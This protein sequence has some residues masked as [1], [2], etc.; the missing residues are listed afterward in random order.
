MA[1]L[2]TAHTPPWETAGP[3]NTQ[4]TAPEG[5]S[6]P[7]F[8]PPTQTSVCMHL[9]TH[10][11]TAASPR[12][13]Q[14]VV[15]WCN[16]LPPT[17]SVEAHQKVCTTGRGLDTT[18][19]GPPC[20]TA[21]GPPWHMQSSCWRTASVLFSCSQNRLLQALQTALLAV[22]TSPTSLPHNLR[23]AAEGGWLSPAC[24]PLLRLPAAPPLPAAPRLPH[25]LRRAAQA[26]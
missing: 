21:G 16:C 6:C 24:W 10:I 15:S 18:S 12:N 25:R 4:P 5:W 1:Q 11:R 20:C 17:Q 2:P 23:R 22:P 13:S 19:R 8:S 9:R 14:G 7:C 26:E 3:A